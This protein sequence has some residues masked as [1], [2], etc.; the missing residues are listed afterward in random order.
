MD[1]QLILFCSNY[2]QELEKLNLPEHYDDVHVAYFP[3]RCG[4]PPIDWSTLKEK[5]QIEDDYKKIN[6]V[7]CGGITNLPESQ[8]I[9]DSHYSYGCRQC[10]HLVIN[11]NLA[12]HYLQ[13]GYY[14]VTPG[15]LMHWRD[16]LS[17]WGFDQITAQKFFSEAAST[18]MLLDTGV[19][20][21]S[22]ANLIEFSLYVKRPYEIVTVGL[23]Y[24]ELLLNNSVLKSQVDAS[25]HS[26]REDLSNSRKELADFAMA[27]DLLNSLARVRQED[28]V[29]D[30]IRDMFNLL[31]APKQ[32]IFRPAAQ[33]TVPNHMPVPV[34]AGNGFIV[35]VYGS[36]GL[37]GEIEVQ[38]LN[39]PQH[40][41]QYLKLANRIV[42][43]CGLAIENTRH[44]QRIKE[45]SDTDG[46]TGIANRRKLEDHLSS[47]W[48]RMQREQKP[49]ALLMCDI[50]YFKNYNDLYGHQAGDECLKVVAAALAK[51]S[52]RSGDLAARYGGE[53]FTMVL[54]SV[55]LKCAEQL[56]EKIRLAIEELMI[57]HDSSSV[58]EYVTL[59]IGV[60][61]VVPTAESSAEKLIAMADSA[62]YTAKAAGRNRV[63][64]A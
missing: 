52:Q 51:H 1:K 9:A 53:E 5:M 7:S 27:L 56:A 13:K 47:E 41:N 23:D 58:S 20:S 64:V 29:L 8:Q 38:G 2:R 39:Q 33:I 44:Y 57:K 22:E 62:L 12:E 28:Q 42:N 3:S 48:R 30:N 24:L 50:D 6:V 21:E 31:F 45:L 46:L 61:C 35:P 16:I 25:S 17:K 34:N 59:S 26:Q 60:A 15:W 54:P 14:L 19:D 4:M 55:D 37:L 43:I 32:V 18:I 63:V 49:L 10:Y 36:E 40:L 11:Q